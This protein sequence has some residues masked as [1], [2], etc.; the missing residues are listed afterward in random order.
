MKKS[1]KLSMYGAIVVVGVGLAV[2]GAS[3][4]DGAATTTD[5]S[6]LATVERGPMVAIGRGDRQDRAD[7]EGRDQVE[8]ERHHRE[9]LR[10]RRFAR[11]AR[12]RCSPSSTRRTST[13]RPARGAGQPRRP[14]RPPSR[15]PEAQREK[16][17][18]EAESPE[19]AFAVARLE[20]ADVAVSPRSS[21]RSRRWTTRGARLE[22]AVNKQRRRRS[23]LASAGAVAQAGAN[24]A[25]ARAAVDAGAGAARQ[26]HHPRA[27]PR[28]RPLA[29]RRDRQPRL[30]HPQPRRQ[31]DAG[32]DAR[33][34]R[35]RSSSAARWTRPTSAR[36]ARTAG[37][38]H[39]SRRSSDRVF[40]GKVTQISP[41]GRREGQR[42]ELRGEGLD[43]KPVGASSRRT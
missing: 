28:H 1:R 19:V 35:A 38:D 17:R 6:R 22:Q 31:R 10:G 29:R 40:T 24:V 14:P 18:I 16:N 30:L 33:R 7:H 23:Q 20:R 27:D 4:L 11:G 37:A 13:R 9:A 8:G 21:S 32:D 34:H 3:T 43:R 39:A 12:G 36:A 2:W 42:H 26:R 41:I 5:P 25:Q 15:R